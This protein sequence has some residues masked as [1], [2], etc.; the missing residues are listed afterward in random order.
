MGLIKKLIHITSYIFYILIGIYILVS[1]P[2]IFGYKPLVV[3]SG[4]MEPTFKKGSIIYYQE[5]TNQKL[6]ENDII[7][8]KDINNNTVSHRIVRILDNG[9]IVLKGD[10][11][12][13]EDLNNITKDQII[14][15]DSN[16]NI[17]LVG[18]YIYIVNKYLVLSIIITI[19]VLV[20]EF[21]LSNININPQGGSNDEKVI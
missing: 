5:Y 6:K 11:N 12:N 4:S 9:E 21:I 2:I 8:Y 17:I 14:G 10:N 16:I 15:I 7:T 19:I 20:S 3:L 18:Y 1:I 13:T